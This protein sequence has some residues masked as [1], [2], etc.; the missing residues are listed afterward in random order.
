MAKVRRKKTPKSSNKK[1]KKTSENKED[2]LILGIVLVLILI[3]T[4]TFYFIQTNDSE[5]EVVAIVNGEKITEQEL[6]FW[7]ELSV[8]P[9]HRDAIKEDDF[10]VMSLIPQKI[11]EQEA[12]KENIIASEEDIEKL[13]GLFV[14]ENG[15][16]LEEFEERLK[17][18]DTTIDDVK[19]SFESRVLAAKLFEKK[20]FGTNPNQGLFFDFADEKVQDYVNGL[21][22]NAVIELF[23]EN[24][25][26][27]D[28]S[29]FEDTGDEL[30]DEEMPIVRLF[31][32]SSCEICGESGAL[33]QDS[34]IKFLVEEKVYA[35]HWSLDTG[36][37]LLSVEKEKGIPQEEAA[38]FKK[39]SPNNKVPL[40]VV[41]CKY[42]RIGKFT[43]EQI[44]E[45]EAIINSI[46]GG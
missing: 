23:P 33:F 4:F 36:D 22:D 10:L 24:I 18:R 8:F 26:K 43:N 29:G 16:S 28:I 3:A 40:I 5:D 34:I 13:V 30:C 39:Y 2:I 15:L 44:A 9:E 11:I 1:T 38:L 27:L 45:F 7:Y 12:D 32:T 19:K 25:E 21:I 35:R 6:D 42:K 14:I 46:S 17:E 20:G 41:G 31:T 37:N